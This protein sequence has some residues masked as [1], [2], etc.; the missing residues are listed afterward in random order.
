MLKETSAGLSFKVG[1]EKKLKTLS[2]SSKPGNRATAR[3]G[4]WSTIINLTMAVS[5]KP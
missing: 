2:Y 3:V 4:S 1:F 5:V